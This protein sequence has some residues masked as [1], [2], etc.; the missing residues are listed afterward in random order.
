ML[1]LCLLLLLLSNAW[2]TDAADL[3]NPRQAPRPDEQLRQ[4]LK[5]YCLSE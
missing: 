2:C 1:I 4:A 5:Q 3:S